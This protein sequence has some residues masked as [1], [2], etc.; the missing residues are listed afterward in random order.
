MLKD[1]TFYQESPVAV[2]GGSTYQREG[3]NTRTPS[4]VVVQGKANNEEKRLYVLVN[5]SKR[6]GTRKMLY[7]RKVAH[8]VRAVVHRVRYPQRDTRDLECVGMLGV[9]AQ[10]RQPHAGRRRIRKSF[11]GPRV[12]H[13]HD[14]TCEH[15][16]RSSECRFKSSHGHRG[17]W[18]TKQKQSADTSGV[19][20][21]RSQESASRRE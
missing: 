9:G 10:S 4:A 15:V 17:A 21:M 5:E 11:R 6:A 3:G 13:Q 18:T 8:S 12:L 14:V 2:C 20:W 19:R 1:G 16:G 7:N